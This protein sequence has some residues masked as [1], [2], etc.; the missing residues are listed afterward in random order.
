MW[1]VPIVIKDKKGQKSVHGFY[2][3]FE[4]FFEMVTRPEDLPANWAIGPTDNRGS[5]IV[6]IRDSRESFKRSRR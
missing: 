5:D 4:A 6:S 1:K 3:L 2:L